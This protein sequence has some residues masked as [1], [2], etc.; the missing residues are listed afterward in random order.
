M[1]LDF[2]V[3]IPYDAAG[4][5]RKKI[6]GIT[7]IYYAY[8]HNYNPE[9]RYTIPRNTSIGKCTEDDPEMMY[10]NNEIPEKMESLIIKSKGNIQ[11]YPD[12]DEDEWDDE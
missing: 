2:K 3:K 6:K 8:E 10:P 4:I 11:Q 5:T 9:K 7:Y 12:W 1:Y